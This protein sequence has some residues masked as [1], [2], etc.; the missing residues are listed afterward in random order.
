MASPIPLESLAKVIQPFY[1]SLGIRT[2]KK[3]EEAI[4]LPI[5]RAIACLYV[6]SPR[7]INRSEDTSV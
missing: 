3:R 2:T 4:D 1:D 7:T 5:G 6:L